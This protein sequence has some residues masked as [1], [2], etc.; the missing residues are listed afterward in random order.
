MRRLSPQGARRSQTERTSRRKRR[1]APAQPKVASFGKEL[2]L[3]AA[4]AR[5]GW[6]VSAPGPAET[7]F[8]IRKRGADCT[9]STGHDGTRAPKIDTCPGG[10]PGGSEAYRVRRGWTAV[11]AI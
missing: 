3:L 5:D 8:Q 1:S 11:K 7:A 2:A 4:F 10:R 9:K 6:C